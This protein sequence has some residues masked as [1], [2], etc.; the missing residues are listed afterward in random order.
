MIGKISDVKKIAR[1]AALYADATV[2]S[3]L[4]KIQSKIGDL[5]EAQVFSPFSDLFMS[6]T[7]PKAIMPFSRAESTTPERS[8]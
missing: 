1:N 6:L 7:L 4:G 5:E 2:E 8:A 3:W